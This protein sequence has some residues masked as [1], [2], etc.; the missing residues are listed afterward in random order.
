[1]FP[2]QKINLKLITIFLILVFLLSGCSGESLNKLWLKSDGWSRGVLLGET[3]MPAPVESAIDDSGNTYVLLFPRSPENERLYQ[4]SISIL[5]DDGEISRFILSDIQMLLPRAAKIFLSAEGLDL[6]WISNYQIF[7]LQVNNNGDLIT[8]VKILSGEEKVNSFEIVFREGEYQIWYA[9]SRDDPGLYTLVGD[10]T[11]WEK[12]L[13]D[14]L[15]INES[16][17]EDNNSQLHVSW[18]Q[19]PRGYDDLKFYYLVDSQDTITAS[20]ALL[21]FSMKINPSIR[22]DGP[23]FNLDQELGYFIWSEAI[24]SGLEAGSRTTYYRYFPLG[25]PQAIRPKMRL[26]V[27]AS[28]NIES[29]EY[30]GGYFQAGDRVLAGGMHPSTASIENIYFLAGQFEETPFVFRSRTEF[31]WR[32]FRNQANIAYLSDGLIT[33]YQPLSYTSAE[34]Y[35]PAVNLDQEMDLYVTWLEK[36]ETTFRAYLTTTD[37]NKKSIIDQV[38]IDDY[39][40]LLAE[41]LFGFM[42]GM[43]LSPFAAAA[44]GGAGLLA[45]VFNIIFSTFHNQFL[46]S[47]GEYLSIAGGIIIF[48][49]VKLATLPG[50]GDDYVPF[51]AWIPRIPVSYE[52]PLIIGVPIL[53]GVVA[54]AAAWFNTFGKKSGSAINFHMI[55]SAI[56]TVL[57]CAIYGILIYGSF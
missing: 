13:I 28:Q 14:P 26:I 39:I 16:I 9:G 18:I 36:G 55:Y 25:E 21:M 24:T 38:S 33:S 34:S 2:D 50:L 40:Y 48:W 35:Y 8:D 12:T 7:Q 3:S 11:G 43:V 51:S 42:A 53:I 30:P 6:F 10:H 37:S 1:M 31:K 5:S 4:P 47:I 57:S 44:W 49:L 22:L 32:D 56:D 54:F 41:G 23:F 29:V 15:G 45:F 17:L 20:D 27:P 46:K 52:Q 19:Y